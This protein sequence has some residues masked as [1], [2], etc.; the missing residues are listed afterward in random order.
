M[1]WLP[2]DFGSQYMLIVTHQEAKL[3]T[4][5]HHD[6][7][8]ADCKGPKSGWGPNSWEFHPFPKYLE[9]SSD[10]LAYEITQPYKNWELHILGPLAFW[11][12]PHS[13]YGVCISLN[14]LSFYYGSLLNSFLWEAR[15]PHSVAIPWTWL[16]PR[17]WLSSHA[18]PFFPVT[19]HH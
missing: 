17:M 9:Y 4:H 19:R 14:N 12:S 2:L 1:S 10:S 6:S 5:R 16:R 13:I 18:P 7:S 15:N 8:K 11:D 3:H